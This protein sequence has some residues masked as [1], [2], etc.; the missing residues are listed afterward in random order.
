MEFRIMKTDIGN[1]NEYFNK[2]LFTDQ[3][4]ARANAKILDFKTEPFVD[5]T[6]EI[7]APQLLNLMSIFL[8]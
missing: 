7:V 1:Y 2:V 5:Q 3:E 8:I 4:S 6:S